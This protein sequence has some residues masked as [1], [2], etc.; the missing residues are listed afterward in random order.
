MTE[1]FKNCTHTLAPKHIKTHVHAY[2]CV[3]LYESVSC[4]IE[5]VLFIINLETFVTH[6]DTATS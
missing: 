3:L 5:V 4:N 1:H 6:W 2:M